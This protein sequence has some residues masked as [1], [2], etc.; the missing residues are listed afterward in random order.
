MTRNH[1][2]FFICLDGIDQCGKSTQVGLLQEKMKA[3]RQ[4]V[5]VFREPGSTPISEDIRRILLSTGNGEIDPLC[6]LLLYSAA[7]AQLMAEMIIPALEK[8]N[9]VILDRFHYSTTAYQ[10]Y[11]RGLSLSLIN[12]INQSTSRGYTPDLTI[13]IDISPE[14]A[15]Q[16][17]DEAGRDRLERFSLDFFRRVREGYLKLAEENPNF[18]LVDGTQPRDTIIE[19]IWKMV[20]EASDRLAR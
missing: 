19:Q 3:R 16:R 20:E 15:M 9:Y 7:R 5:L 13:I 4:D 10:G 8:G 11:G 18:A 14:A 1:N 17:R 12:S 6:E 2:G